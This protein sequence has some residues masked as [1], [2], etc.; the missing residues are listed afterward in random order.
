MLWSGLNASFLSSSDEGLF[1][2]ERVYVCHH[3]G[4]RQCDVHERL[5]GGDYVAVR[6]G[7][8]VGDVLDPSE[9]RVLDV[10]Q[11][12]LVCVFLRDNDKGRR[13]LDGLCVQPVLGDVQPYVDVAE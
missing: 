6:L 12:I 1:T 3:V 5:V 9:V 10:Q 11:E 13:P 2:S 7:V 4:R 8:L